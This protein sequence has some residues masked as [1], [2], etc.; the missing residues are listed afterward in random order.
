[1][2]LS[3]RAYA[4]VLKVNG[5]HVRWTINTITRIFNTIRKWTGIAYPPHDVTLIA[6]VRVYQSKDGSYFVKLGNHAS[7]TAGYWF[8]QTHEESNHDNLRT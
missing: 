4:K 7:F 1:M 5:D 6:T 2:R 8:E 3:E